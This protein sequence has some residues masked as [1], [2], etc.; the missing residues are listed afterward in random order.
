MRRSEKEF[1]PALGRLAGLT[2][3]YVATDAVTGTV[4]HVSSWDSLEHAG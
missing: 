3:Y 4:V 1:A 2:G